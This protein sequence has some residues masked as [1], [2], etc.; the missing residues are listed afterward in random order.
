LLILFWFYY[1]L[2]EG[3]KSELSTSAYYI[4]VWVTVQIMTSWFLSCAHI[5]FPSSWRIIIRILCRERALWFLDSLNVISPSP[6]NKSTSIHRSICIYLSIYL[7]IYPS[8][9]MLHF[10]LGVLESIRWF[11]SKWCSAAV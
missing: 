5:L 11:L 8:I 6:S 7:S 4:D 9:S 2:M 3:K 10:L 1:G